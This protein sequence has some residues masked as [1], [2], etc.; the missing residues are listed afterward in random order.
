[1]IGLAALKQEPVPNL[2]ADISVSDACL[3][4]CVTAEGGSRKPPLPFSETV[5]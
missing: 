5:G 2:G 4:V 3:F 1:L